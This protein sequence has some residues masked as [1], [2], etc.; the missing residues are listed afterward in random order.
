VAAD[1]QMRLRVPAKLH[2]ELDFWA[3]REGV[4]RPAF[5]VEALRR[6]VADLAGGGRARDDAVMLALERLSQAVNRLAEL[7]TDELDETLED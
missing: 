2:A 3:E 4:G 5:C 7:L 1:I 6:C